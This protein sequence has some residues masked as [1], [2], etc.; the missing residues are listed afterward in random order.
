MPL[1][2]LDLSSQLLVEDEWVLAS[3]SLPVNPKEDYQGGNRCV[4]YFL[5][6]E[7]DVKISNAISLI[8]FFFLNNIQFIDLATVVVTLLPMLRTSFLP[9]CEQSFLS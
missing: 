7:N 9:I 3:D 1:V 6:I 5:N 2:R 4:P 8:Q